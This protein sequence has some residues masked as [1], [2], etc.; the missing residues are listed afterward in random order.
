MGG[1]F[2]MATGSRAERRWAVRLGCVI[3]LT[4]TVLGLGPAAALAM[5]ANPAGTATKHALKG[6]QSLKLASRSGR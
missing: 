4:C 6:G 1:R 2:W 3:A 5:P